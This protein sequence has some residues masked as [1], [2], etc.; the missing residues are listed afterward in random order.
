MKLGSLIVEPGNEYATVL[1]VSM[2]GK[3]LES[4]AKVL[5]QCGTTMRPTGWAW[6]AATHEGTNGQRV[7]KTGVM[8]WWVVLE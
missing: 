3:P 5:V 2:D 1:L 6:K 4:S 7:V 8:P